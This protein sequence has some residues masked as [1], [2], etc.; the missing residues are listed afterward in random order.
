MLEERYRDRQCACEASPVKIASKRFD[1]SK[2]LKIKL[3]QFYLSSSIVT[4]LSVYIDMTIA[5]DLPAGFF[6]LMIN[7]SHDLVMPSLRHISTLAPQGLSLKYSSNVIS[8][9]Q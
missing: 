1:N 7:D 5:N 4:W 8:I 3:Q 9:L 2:L 6:P